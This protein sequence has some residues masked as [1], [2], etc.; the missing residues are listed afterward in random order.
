VYSRRLVQLL[1]CLVGYLY[2][3]PNIQHGSRRTTTHLLTLVLGEAQ[4]CDIAIHVACYDDSHNN[5]LLRPRKIPQINLVFGF[6]RDNECELFSTAC[7]LARSTSS[8]LIESRLPLLSQRIN[9]LTL[10]PYST[11][12]HSSS[13]RRL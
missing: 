3:S 7:R 6:L 13:R 9:L 11:L 2:E 5:Q 10:G 4:R 12:R 8:Q 1:Y